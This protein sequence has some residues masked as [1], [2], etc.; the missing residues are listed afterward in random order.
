MVEG[1]MPD[2]AH[3]QNPVQAVWVQGRMPVHT[4]R[5]WLK[6]RSRIRL[7][8][9][10]HPVCAYRCPQCGSLELFAR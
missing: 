3:Y 10:E 2:F 5:H 9:N 6:G 1:F 4:G 8:E 7:P